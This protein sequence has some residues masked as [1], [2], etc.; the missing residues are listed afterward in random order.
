MI[1]AILHLAATTELP[2]ALVDENG[3]PLL[4]D[5]KVTNAEGD[6]MH[7]VRMTPAQLDE[8]RPHVT[9]LAESP[10]T[11]TGTA[12]R[13]YE[14]I[15]N[16]PEKLAL[17]ESVYDI[18]PCEIDDGEGG[19]TTYTPPFKFGMLAESKLPVPESVTSRQGMEQLIRSG[20]D[21]QVD[22]AIDA[23]EDP[24][25]RKLV[26][27]WLDKADVWERHNPQFI[28]MAA[29]L[30]LTPGQTDDYVRQAD[31]L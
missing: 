7:Y 2:S 1:D 13:V 30:G 26:R 22:A 28:S 29:T 14:Q 12:D 17:Y 9:V 21:E 16:D 8:W 31:L 6:R 20:L 11:G 19:T 15:I 24:L 27:N 4:S 18:S 25:E 23:I 3:Q 10:Y 5:P